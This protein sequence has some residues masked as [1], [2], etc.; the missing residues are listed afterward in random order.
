MHEL[1]LLIKLFHF[2]VECYG[3]WT[4]MLLLEGVPFIGCDKPKPIQR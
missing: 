3:F 1:I 2:F 4:G